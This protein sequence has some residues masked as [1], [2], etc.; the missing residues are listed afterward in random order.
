MTNTVLT[1]KHH[2]QL[3]RR[4]RW[5]SKYDQSDKTKKARREKLNEKLRGASAVLMLDKKKG[6]TYGSNMA[7][8]H[9][10]G[11]ALDGLEVVEEVQP[12]S[13]KNEKVPPRKKATCDA[14]H[15]VGHSSS[16][17]SKERL[18]TIKPLS[19]HYKPENVGAKRKF[20]NVLLVYVTIICVP[21]SWYCKP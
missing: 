8:P 12:S 21:D 17:N 9:I 11:M 19:K 13:K 14:C 18:L 2:Q 1:T 16:K 5:K 7:G 3:D 15:I 4:R 6:K 10:V 20:C